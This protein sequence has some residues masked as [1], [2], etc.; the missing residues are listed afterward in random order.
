MEEHAP[1]QA[2][3]PPV[4]AAVDPK[5]QLLNSLPKQ[6]SGDGGLFAQLT[7]NPLFTAVRPTIYHSEC[8]ANRKTSRAS[9]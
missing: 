1:V 7:G 5:E 3:P 6:T 8:I 2:L 4:P 9:V